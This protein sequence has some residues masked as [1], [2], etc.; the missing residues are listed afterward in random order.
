M[1]NLPTAGL[2]PWFMVVGRHCCSHIARW[3]DHIVISIC[4]SMFAAVWLWFIWGGWF[5]ST[6]SINIF[7]YGVGVFVHFHV[8]GRVKDSK[9]ICEQITTNDLLRTDH[10]WL[11]RRVV[12]IKLFNLWPA[13]LLL[14]LLIMLCAVVAGS[15]AVST[16]MF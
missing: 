11:V 7:W 10:N 2:R 16:L 3:I 4:C 1:A 9:I 14:V 5:I 13:L 8:D 15:P 12:A 6:E